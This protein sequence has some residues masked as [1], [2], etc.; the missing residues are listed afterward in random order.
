M[1][2]AKALYDSAKEAYE[3]AS[4]ELDDEGPLPSNAVLRQT[5]ETKDIM[6]NAYVESVKRYNN[7]LLAN[8]GPESKT[9]EAGS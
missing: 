2:Q 8:L 1:E 6:L 4:Q 7:Y 3:R 9:R 5:R